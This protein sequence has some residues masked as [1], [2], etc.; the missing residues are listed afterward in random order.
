MT[1]GLGR[2]PPRPLR[3]GGTRAGHGA[4]PPDAYAPD[5]ASAARL[6]CA[7]RTRGRPV[8]R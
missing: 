8:R 2:R 4:L 7:V 1:V 6:P 5:W 3:T